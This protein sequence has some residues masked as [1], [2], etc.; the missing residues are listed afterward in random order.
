MKTRFGVFGIVGSLLLGGC[1][2]GG[3]APEALGQE[4]SDIVGGTDADIAAF[5]HQVSL[6]IDGSHFCGGSVLDANWV[7]TAQHCVKDV[8]GPWLPP[9]L[10]DVVAGTSDVTEFA[11]A[12]VRDV[13]EIIPLAGFVD[14]TTGKDVALLRLAT[15]LDLSTP[16]VQPIRLVTSADEAAG[17]TAPGVIATATGWGTLREGGQP[18]AVLQAVEVPIVANADASPAYEAI[19]YPALSSDQLAAGFLGVGGKDSCQGDSGGPLTVLLGGAPALAGVVSWGEGCARPDFAGL[20][21][22]V[23]SFGSWISSVQNSTLSKLLT[24]TNLS[25]KLNRFQYFTVNVPAA[26]L[27][28]NISTTGGS[29]DADLYVRFGSR[30]T[31]NSYDC[32]PFLSGNDESCALA[33][34][35]AGTWHIALKGFSNFSGLSLTATKR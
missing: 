21:G 14:P 32:R 17:A 22:R 10:V 19:G 35:K 15:P 23:A 2:G 6:Q 34:P 31:A 3:D 33:S 27:A 16:A 8:I 26:A 20:Y 12:Q 4:Q 9:A 13:S 28:L 18:S 30:P 24:R 5:P 1:L 7:L 25:G 29:G 11:A